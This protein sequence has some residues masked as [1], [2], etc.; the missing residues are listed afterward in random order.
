[1]TRLPCL[2][3]SPTVAWDMDGAGLSADLVLD[4]DAT[5]A[6][7]IDEQGLVAKYGA[8]P[9]ARVYRTTVQAI[10]SPV[11]I[12]FNTTRWNTGGLVDGSSNIVTNTGGLW[13][14]WAS[15][16]ITLGAVVEQFAYMNILAT[17]AVVDTVAQDTVS[18]TQAPM[19]GTAESIQ[20]EASG[21]FE[22]AA[23]TTF[24]VQILHNFGG[25]VN[26]VPSSPA[27][28]GTAAEFAGTEMFAC[29]VVPF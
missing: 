13:Y 14:V 5:N 19:A 2:L 12:A 15:V 17:G 10:G 18:G 28:V 25:T 23:A 24:S 26:T 9:T 21:Y 11:T 22:C 6:L 4:P 27:A 20:L 7:A 29:L 8:M 3:D 16:G 1:M